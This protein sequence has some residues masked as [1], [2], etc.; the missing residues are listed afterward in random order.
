VP[1]TREMEA[2]ADELETTLGNKARLPFKKTNQTK[3]INKK[4][5]EIYIVTVL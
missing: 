3:Q 4:K 2:T 1:A 5:R